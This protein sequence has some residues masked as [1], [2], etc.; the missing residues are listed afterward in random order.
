[1][2]IASFVEVQFDLE[3]ASAAKGGPMFNTTVL[4]LA[5][6]SESRN[7]NWSRERPM[8][9]IS[10]GIRTVEDF[11]YYQKFFFAR[12]GKAVGFRFPDPLDDR[13]PFWNDTPGDAD[14]LPVLFTTDGVTT[15]FQLTKTYTDAGGTFTR[16]IKKPRSGTL[17]L[18]D[19]HSPL[20]VLT[21]GVN[22]T[23]DYTTGIVTLTGALP[24]SSNHEIIGHYEFDIPVRFDT[25][26]LNASVNAGEVVVWDSIPV[27]GLKL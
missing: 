16:I 5:S 20:T 6:G 21:A 15:T 11:R 22:Y 25:D 8:W 13:C 3:I 18:Y 23:V 26:Q 4:T 14:S 9:D 24:T 7:I 19:S 2:T 1:M 27:V 12:R 17:V 10:P